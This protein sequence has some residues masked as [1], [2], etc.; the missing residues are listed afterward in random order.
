MQIRHAVSPDRLL[1]HSQILRLQHICA[2]HVGLLLLLEDLGNRLTGLRD[3]H[4]IGG[5]DGLI[6]V[7]VVARCSGLYLSLFA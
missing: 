6:D 5:V 3:R 2:C 4:A 1:L 7:L